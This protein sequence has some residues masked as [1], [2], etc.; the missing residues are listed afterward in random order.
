ML[1]FLM[2]QNFVKKF[3][4]Q[5]HIHICMYNNEILANKDNNKL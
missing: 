5:K 3:L 4:D 1:R 2:S